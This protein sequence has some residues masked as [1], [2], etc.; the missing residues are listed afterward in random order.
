M[1]EGSME[2][3]TTEALTRLLHEAER[4]HGEYEATEL[5]GVY[6]VEWARWYAAYAV[7]HGIGDLL[8]RPVTVDELAEALASRFAEFDAT[9]PKPAEG[10]AA[11]IARRL[12]EDG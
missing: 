3:D 10:W 11:F 7:E 8:G 6:D 5:N 4:A 2:P 12:A 1:R 9:E